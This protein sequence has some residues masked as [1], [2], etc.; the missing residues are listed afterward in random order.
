MG[1]SNKEQVQLV[2]SHLEG[3][4]GNFLG[5]LFAATNHNLLAKFRMDTNPHPV[6]LSI[7]G[8]KDWDQ[9]I[10]KLESHKVVV[11]HCYNQQL[12]AKTFPNAQIVALYP[13]T[14]IGNV[15]YNICFKKLTNKISNLVDGHLIH[16]KQWHAHLIAQQPQYQCHDFWKLTD[17]DCIENFL[18]IKLNKTQIDFFED[19]WKQQMTLPLDLPQLPKTVPELLEQW[20]CQDR[21]DNWLLAWTIYVYELINGLEE[22]QRAWSIDTEKFKDWNDVVAIQFKYDDL[23]H[24]STN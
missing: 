4:S 6:V 24:K 22:S 11:T 15:L 14:H 8:V 5:R 16:I 1:I 20:Q 17:L 19:Y 23:P 3:C 12:I 9:W 18:N 2:I 10:Q 21:F 13:Y 7:D